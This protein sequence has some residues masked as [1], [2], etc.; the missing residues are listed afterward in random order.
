MTLELGSGR[1]CEFPR[2]PVAL[3]G[4]RLISQH[5]LATV[6]NLFSSPRV[7]VLLVL[8]PRLKS[9]E[10]PREPEAATSNVER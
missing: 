3:S 8:I 2:L 5:R 10:S 4:F 6:W 1:C 9:T 7:F